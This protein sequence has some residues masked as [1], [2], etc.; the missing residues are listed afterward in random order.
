MSLILTNNHQK[1]EATRYRA[2]Q[3]KKNERKKNRTKIW[4]QKGRN[5]GLFTKK[6]HKKTNR[7]VDKD[8]SEKI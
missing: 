8:Y 6:Q 4:Q 1:I 2:V 5:P 7:K 3:P